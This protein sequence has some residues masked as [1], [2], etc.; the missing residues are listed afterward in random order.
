MLLHCQTEQLLLIVD[1]ATPPSRPVT[2]PAIHKVPTCLFSL[3]FD[4]VQVKGLSYMPGFS[5]FSVG[6]R[7][8]KGEIGHQIRRAWMNPHLGLQAVCDDADKGEISSNVES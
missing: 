3:M 7:H 5:Y 4:C 6:P 2:F 8:D 1:A